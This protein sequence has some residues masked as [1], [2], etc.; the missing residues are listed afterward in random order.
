MKILLMGPPG[1][2]KGTLGEMLSQKM[3]VSL[4][5]VG[6]TLRDLSKNSPEGVRIHAYLDR[7]EL[8]P[9]DLVA[10]ILKVRLNKQDCQKGFILDGW[11]RKLSDIQIFDPGFDKVVVLNISNETIIKR[12]SGRR[13][14]DTDGKIYNI[15]TFSEED[16]KKCKGYLTQRSDDTEEV[17]KKRIESYQTE[18]LPTIEYFRN[19]NL[20]V[21]L[22]AEGSPNTAF[23][24]LCTALGLN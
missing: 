10:Q 15:Y 20:L 16:L 14:C 13:M 2:G 18:T 6:Q 3:G 5:S 9:N 17:V 23:K 19:R 4:I 11:G 22:D 21:E 1:S 8:A 12:I 7:G 24:N